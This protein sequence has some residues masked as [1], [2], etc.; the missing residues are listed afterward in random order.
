MSM[1]LGFGFLYCEKSLTIWVGEIKKQKKT[2]DYWP[3]ILVLFGTEKYLG[4]L[5]ILLILFLSFKA[6]R[7]PNFA[8]LGLM[9]P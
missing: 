1:F 7:G 4:K 9:N 2:V 3:Q 6:Y 5:L 8:L